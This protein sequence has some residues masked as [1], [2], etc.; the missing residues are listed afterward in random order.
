MSKVSE[1]SFGGFAGGSRVEENDD[2]KVNSVSAQTRVGESRE[3]EV[4]SEGGS[5]NELNALRNAATRSTTGQDDFKGKSVV[6]STGSRSN[7]TAGGK[8][9]TSFDVTPPE[10]ALNGEGKPIM[11]CSQKGTMVPVSPGEQ[12]AAIRRASE[13]DAKRLA[14]GDVEDTYGARVGVSLSLFGFKAGLGIGVH[15]IDKDNAV[16]VGDVEYGMSNVIGVGGDVS[17]EKSNAKTAEDFEGEDKSAGTSVSIPYF[18]PSAGMSKS[19]NGESHSTSA[20]LGF[21]VKRGALGKLIQPIETTAEKSHSA[22]L[23]QFDPTLGF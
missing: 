16:L 22:V 12:A 5:N 23:G 9:L 13:R 15:V 4:D 17:L 18:G 11:M 21:S 19:I 3:P 2:K 8:N 20:T 10:I 14:D 7:S 1:A 6:T